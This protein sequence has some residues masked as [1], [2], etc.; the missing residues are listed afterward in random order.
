MAVAGGDGS[1]NPA[2]L[3]LAGTKTRLA[4]LPA[5]TGNGLAR[6][7][8]LPL[9]P[10]RALGLLQAGKTR[11][12]DVIRLGQG[13]GFVNVA[14]C[15]LDADIAGKANEL[16]WVGRASG[17]LR[18]LLAGALGL[19][20]FKPLRLES[21]LGRRVLRGT[22]L[23]VALANSPQYGFGTTIAPGARMDDGLMDLVFL[24]PLSLSQVLRNF[25]RLFLK[26]RL[27][28]A[29]YARA[30]ELRL[31][32]LAGPAQLHSDGEAAGSLPL[33]AKVLPRSLTIFVP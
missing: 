24:S 31:R 10:V 14:G 4:L 23:Q 1:F 27:L 19:L 2:G 22:Y 28:G 9:D 32:S 3:A 21:R 26:Q 15:G 6:A 11:K 16:R 18:Y 8:G 25:P 29:T 33:H 20:R 17:F 13:R 7:L 5:G 30:K 12:I